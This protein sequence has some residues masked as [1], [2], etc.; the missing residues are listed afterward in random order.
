MKGSPD[1]NAFK[2]TPQ[3]R[4]LVAYMAPLSA[5]CAP[6]ITPEEFQER[7]APQWKYC[8]QQD[9]YDGTKCPCSTKIVWM[10][11]MR[12]LILP[13]NEKIYVGSTC[14]K[15]FDPIHCAVIEVENALNAGV[16]AWYESDTDS[17]EYMNFKIAHDNS[18]VITRDPYI[19]QHFGSSPL[20]GDKI[21]V[22]KKEGHPS[23]V[24]GEKYNIT[25]R[26]KEDEERGV[27]YNFYSLKE[28][29]QATRDNEDYE[30][31]VQQPDESEEYSSQSSGSGD[32]YI[33]MDEESS[34]SSLSHSESAKRRKYD[35]E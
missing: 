32:D 19:K 8:Y 22:K 12:N 13:D 21:L 33:D 31:D 26:M 6:D 1:F 5:G 35:L 10:C 30:P 11:Y 17:G 18:R 15:R 7:I 4:K 34:S 25:C 16:V 3:F 2:I 27:I 9:S 23:L 28:H 24:I 20:N 14:V 29:K